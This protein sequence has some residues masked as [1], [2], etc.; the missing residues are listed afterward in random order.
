MGNLLKHARFEVREVVG[1]GVAWFRGAVEADETSEDGGGLHEWPVTLNRNDKGGPELDSGL[2]SE[3]G[4]PG[5]APGGGGGGKEQQG[6]L[7]EWM[8]WG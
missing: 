2:G 6:G 1:I 4:I 7:K 3:E 5:V 8:V